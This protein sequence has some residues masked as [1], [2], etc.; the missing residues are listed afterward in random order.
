MSLKRAATY[1]MVVGSFLGGSVPLFWGA[2]SLSI[3]SALF[4][5]LGGLLG[6]VVS[7]KIYQSFS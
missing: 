7:Y 3:S 4:A 2:D 5:L 1:G 6:I